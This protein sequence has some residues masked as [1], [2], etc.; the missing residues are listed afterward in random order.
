[1]NESSQLRL[2]E[3]VHQLLEGER[4]PYRD[5]LAV[6]WYESFLTWKIHPI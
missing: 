6:L 3:E 5:F 4:L 1:M 2:E